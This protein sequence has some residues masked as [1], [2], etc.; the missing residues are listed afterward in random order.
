MLRCFLL[1]GSIE[2]AT[3]SIAEGTVTSWIED[4]PQNGISLQ[5]PHVYHSY[6]DSP[7]HEAPELPSVNHILQV[8]SELI[9][10]HSLCMMSFCVLPFRVLQV[11]LSGVFMCQQ[12]C[13]DECFVCSI[14]CINWYS[15]VWNYMYWKTM[16]TNCLYSLPGGKRVYCNLYFRR[17]WNKQRCICL[18]KG[19]TVRLH[20]Y[21][22]HI[23]TL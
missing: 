13:G 2:L 6:E 14:A 4:E 1:I 20:A 10:Q 9:H 15:F 12:R 21:Y 19:G 23:A 8:L 5:R 18:N 22:L 7:P 17:S 16:L 3:S 11:V